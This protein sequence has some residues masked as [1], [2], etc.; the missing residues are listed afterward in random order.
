MSVTRV[1]DGFKAID[2][3]RELR[4]GWDSYAADRPGA[5]A[6]KHARD[7][8]SSVSQALGSA[9]VNP[10]VDPIPDPGVALVWRKKGHGEVDALFSASTSRY[11]VI[12][13]K[14]EIV[15]KGEL[16]NY[17]TF[18]LQVLKPFVSL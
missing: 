8:L 16:K 1:S 2:R 18:A 6:L 15:T 14:R 17:E 3:L 12:D 11:V 4:A 10:A 5:L 9:Y 13:S 7:C